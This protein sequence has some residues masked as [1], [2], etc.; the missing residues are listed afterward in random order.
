MLVRGARFA[1]LGWVLVVA[2]GCDNTIRVDSLLDENGASAANGTCTLREALVAA[3]TNAAVDTCIAGQPGADVISL[4]AGTIALTLVGTTDDT[5]DLDLLQDVSLVGA[6]ADAT[7]IDASAIADRV[8]DVAA[9]VTASLT[10]LTVRGGSQTGGVGV[11]VT[12]GGIQNAGTLTVTRAAV[13]DNALHTGEATLFSSTGN[14]AEG[15]GIWS[16]GALALIGSEV[17]GN[18]AEGGPGGANC[19]SLSCYTFPG[20]EGRGGG[21]FASGAVAIAD[22]TVSGNTARGGAG[23]PANPNGFPGYYLQSGGG[24]AVGGGVRV[25]S[26]ATLA[27]ERSTV[28]GNVA[29]G[30][31]GGAG[32][33]APTNLPGATGGSA[34]GGAIF[35]DVSAALTNST[36]T[37]NGAVGGAGGDP[38]G[39]AGAANGGALAGNAGVALTHATLSANGGGTEVAVGTGTSTI[40]NT[41]LAAS[42]GGLVGASLGGNVESPGD[43]CGLT[44]PDDRVTVSGASL[45]LAALAANGGPTE[46]QAI[47]PTSAAAGAGRDANCLPTDQRGVARPA[48]A[49]DSGAFEAT[50]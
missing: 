21:V 32:L 49:C 4:P 43:T 7:I 27:I 19:L 42:C 24:G 28:A 38:G 44:E 29:V 15:G 10:D 34:V 23:R 25:T 22:S 40:A 50:E 11:L 12:G 5:G 3:N 16:S 37:G 6:G 31:V 30:G 18:L 39:N 35:A 46:T 17:A 2:A 41:I 20:G 1:V 45:E 13:R 48:S 14:H 26:T 36:V 9:G 8:I 33:G 47:T